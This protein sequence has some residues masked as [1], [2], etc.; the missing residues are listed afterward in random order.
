[1]SALCETREEIWMYLQ[2]ILPAE[3]VLDQ[4]CED[5]REQCMQWVGAETSLV[6]IRD[7]EKWTNLQ[8]SA[9]W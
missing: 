6:F 1:M 4:R 5:V 2:R 7:A 3:S 8:L 9:E